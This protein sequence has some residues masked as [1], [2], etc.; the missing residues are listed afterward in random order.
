MAKA[1]MTLTVRLPEYVTPR[2]KWRRLILKA[3]RREQNRKGIK[4]SDSER[5]EL[6]V[7]FYLQHPA[8]SMHDLDNRLKDIMDALQGRIGGPKARKPRNPIIPNDSQVWRILAE[9][10]APPPQSHGLGHLTIRRFRPARR[11]SV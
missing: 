11:R 2:L 7:R 3:V 8:L 6:R 1:R 10:G 5:L 9:K 4:Y